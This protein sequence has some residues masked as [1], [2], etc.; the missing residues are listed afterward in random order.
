MKQL[1]LNDSGFVKHRKKTRKAQFLA[2]M[3]QVVP[4]SRLVALI[5]PHY[6]K[7]GNGRRPIALE[8]MLRIHFMQQWFAYSDPAM[9][10][11]LH[12]IPLL[13]EF[14][15]LDAT[16]EAIPDETTILKFRHLLER[17][18]LAG[19]LFEEI[20]GL[21]GERGLILRKGTMVDATLIAAPTST[22]NAQGKR[23]PEM[24]STKKGNQWYF[25]MKAHVGVDTAHGLVHTVVGTAAKVPDVVVTD[26]LLHGEECEVHGDKGYTTR[27]RNLSASDPA[28]GPLWCFPFKR[29]RGKELP[30][31]KH[32]INHRLSQLR[33]RVEHPFR[34][35][36]RQFG[37]TKVRYRGLAKN[38]AQLTTLF[39]LS[40]LY[41]VRRQL[42]RE[43][44]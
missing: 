27:E 10:E 19:A 23:D 24:S 37:H 2:E 1:G 31:W 20:N 8:T 41:L 5:E 38:T 42:L 16:V 30:E 36:K 39:A 35:I 32:D 43:T 44:G 13:R 21:L 11:A 26:E 34:V 40:N 28:S 3:N 9:E 29:H 17:Q 6:P 7:P 33:A 4:W 12:D 22:K 15:G 18:G 25:G 14:A